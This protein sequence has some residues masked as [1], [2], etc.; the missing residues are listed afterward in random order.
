MWERVTVVHIN[1]TCKNAADKIRQSIR[2]FAAVYQPPATILLISGDVNFASDLSDLRF[3]HHYHVILLHP[4]TTAEALIVCA[5]EHHCFEEISD[6]RPQRTGWG[7]SD[8]ACSREFPSREIGIF[9]FSHFPGR[10]SGNSGKMD[11]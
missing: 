4:K 3:R 8:R 6:H 7:I 9:K 11:T 5:H 10:R 2:R 1:S